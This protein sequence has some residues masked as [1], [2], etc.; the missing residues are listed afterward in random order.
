MASTSATQPITTIS[1]DEDDIN[2]M[3]K[4]RLSLDHKRHQM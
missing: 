2:F 1:C 3:S 4:L